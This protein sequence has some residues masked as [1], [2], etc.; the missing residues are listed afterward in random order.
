MISPELTRAPALLW[1]AGAGWRMIASTI[2]GGGLGERAWVLNAQVGDG[3]SRLDPDVHLTE[4]AAGLP[5]D[6]V[7]MLTATDV[8]RFRHASD[9]GVEALATVAIGYPTWAAAPPPERPTG[10]GTINLVIAVPAALSDAALVNA[11][12]TA[13]E[14]KVQAVLEAGYACTGTASDAICVASRVDGPPA[15]FAGP[16]SDWGARIA[17]AVHTVVHTG[18]LRFADARRDYADEL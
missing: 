8:T 4:L 14:A 1:R 5:G 15:H 16:R 2:L 12:A 9:G 7:G 10:P 6:G 18:A 3:Y 11:V 17:R 13:T